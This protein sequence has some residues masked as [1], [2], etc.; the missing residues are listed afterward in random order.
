MQR[1]S[2][3][4]RKTGARTG[5]KTRQVSRLSKTS[6]RLSLRFPPADQIYT[7]SRMCAELVWC[8]PPSV[9]LGSIAVFGPAGWT[10][11]PFV[12]V[13]SVIGTL[14]PAV[15]TPTY[16]F[17]FSLQFSMTSLS[18]FDDL[19]NVFQEY[20]IR[21]VRL[22]IQLLN[23]PTGIV[24]N[25]AAA[26]GEVIYSQIPE[27]LLVQND[28]GSRFP[29]TPIQAQ[30]NMGVQRFMLNDVRPHVFQGVPKPTTVVLGTGTPATEFALPNNNA[31]MWINL[32]ASPNVPHYMW[33]GLMQAWPGANVGNN[34]LVRFSATLLFDCRRTY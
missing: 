15:G 1:T 28:T 4:R 11:E 5:A 3:P 12:V 33:A 18:V 26:A 6:R 29:Q 31:S 32:S 10:G 13:P 34:M 27:M 19:Q 20:R 23:S 14:E 17:P 2:Q 8:S 30:Q 9:P 16:Y 7:F 25:P 22:S 24:A 21:G